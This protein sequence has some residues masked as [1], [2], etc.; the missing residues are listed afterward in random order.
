MSERINSA[1]NDSP[2]SG[3]EWDILTNYTPQ[4]EI[5]NATKSGRKIEQ[6]G[7][8]KEIPKFADQVSDASR[9]QAI[10]YEASTIA[11]Y[12]RNYDATR[13][14]TEHQALVELNDFLT[15]ASSNP[16]I[17]E[18]LRQEAAAMTDSLTFIGHKEF[19]EGA[20][21]LAD[22][23][24]SH[25]DDDP[26]NKLLIQLM[27]EAGSNNTSGITKSDVFLLDEIMRNF[28]DEDV[29][30]YA[31]RLFRQ[32]DDI[33]T[34]AG[35]ENH[36][37][38]IVL[39][40]WSISG[41]QMRSTQRGILVGRWDRNDEYYVTPEINLLVGKQEQIEHGFQYL[42][43]GDPVPMKAYYTARKDARFAAAGLDVGEMGDY[44]ITGFYSSVDYGFEAQIGD[45]VAQ[46]G[47]ELIMPP[48]TNIK[49][50]YREESYTPENVERVFG[51]TQHEAESDT[52]SEYQ[53]A[54]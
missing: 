15:S 20:A 10:E 41:E 46:S 52:S 54:A 53:Q 3:T 19:V 6:L 34:I 4:T 51:K 47:G 12:G 2:P 50:P 27:S 1:N 39:D 13:T 17:D 42:G 49:R 26:K 37:K 33:A 44:R 21:G 48:L 14:I 24:K 40:D 29:E 30:K 8:A 5:T 7:Y 32:P 16:K 11:Q 25:L 43:S 36:L 45:M 31:G 23:W 28:S 35:E 9:T 18:S 38:V 22:Y